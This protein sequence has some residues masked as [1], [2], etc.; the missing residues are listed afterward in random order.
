MEGFKV[1]DFRLITG[2]AK[3]FKTIGDKLADTAAEDSLFTEEIRFRFF[4]EV[5]WMTP[6]R[7]PPMPRA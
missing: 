4:L 7:V 6:A 3:G 5:V 1:S 2:F